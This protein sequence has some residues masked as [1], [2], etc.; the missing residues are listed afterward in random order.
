MLGDSYWSTLRPPPQRPVSEWADT[1]R[2]LTTEDSAQAGQ[3]RTSVVPYMREIMDRMSASDPCE[4]CVAMLASQI[5]KTAA[6]LN[7]VGA[8]ATDAPNTMLYIMDTDEGVK[9]TSKQ[10]I[11]PM[12]RASAALRSIFAKEAG[13]SGSSSMHFREFRGGSLRMTSLQSPAGMRGSPIKY[14]F[15]DEC[16]NS[17]ESVGGEGDP[18]KLAEQRT[19]AQPGRKIM[20]TSTPLLVNTS[21][22]LKEMQKTGWREYHIPCPH[23]GEAEPWTWEM[24]QWT[25]GQ[26]ETAMLHCNFCGTGIEERRKPELVRLGTWIPKHPEREDGRVYGYHAE[27]LIAPYGWPGPLW[28]N[29]VREYEEACENPLLMQTFWNL[30]RGLPYDDTAASTVDP[31]GLAARAEHYAAQVPAGGVVLTAGVDVQ[32]DRVEATVY[33]WG[34]GEECWMVDH[35]VIAGD[36]SGP[37]LWSDLDRYLSQRFEHESGC[38]MSIDSVCVDSGFMATT[39]Q[40]WCAERRGRRVWAVKGLNAADPTR[41]V[42]PHRG[43]RGKRGS[44][45]AVYMVG[46]H[47]AKDALWARLQR[48]PPGPGS[49]HTPLGEAAPDLAWYEQM[50]SEQLRMVDGRRR[51]VRPR[52]VKSEALDCWVYAYAA[53]LSMG[54]AART[55]AAGNARLPSLPRVPAP[56]APPPPRQQPSRKPSGGRGSWLDRGARLR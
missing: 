29:L 27:A 20:I 54:A 11:A 6:M 25:P 19:S 9:T 42:W 15:V 56:S 23:C 22:I 43:S 17:L 21:R 28:A 8:L 34:D 36:P 52:G 50:M 30:K 7:V 24:M 5:G 26:P 10:R 13:R 48:E 49:I 12:I 51:W 14:L 1:H 35:A 47:A 37:A 45:H 44:G 41:A 3:W 33:A 53:L 2:V 32:H 38:L 31:D 46:V 18:I 40:A 4:K 39:V 16:D 55:I